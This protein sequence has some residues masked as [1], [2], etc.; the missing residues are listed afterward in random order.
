MVDAYDSEE[1]MG[2][3]MEILTL[4]GTTEFGE[5]AISGSSRARN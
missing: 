5:I 3:L 1:E 4:A 2:E